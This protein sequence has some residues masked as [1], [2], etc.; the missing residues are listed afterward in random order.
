VVWDHLALD[1]LPAAARRRAVGAVVVLSALS[2]AVALD[3]PL[4]DH[5]LGFGARLGPLGSLAAFWREPLSAALDDHLAGRL[6]VDLLPREHAAAWRPDPSRYDLRRVAL[7][8]ARGRAV[9]HDAKAAKGSLA[10]ALVAS[11]DPERTLGTWRHPTLR[12]AV[13]NDRPTVTGRAAGPR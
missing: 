8:D 1:D 3:D 5:R 9:G 13:T 7:V 10:R 6:V 4:P 12:L 2:G 11:R